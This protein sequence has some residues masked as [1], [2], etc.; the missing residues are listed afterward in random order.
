MSDVP[1]CA[2]TELGFRSVAGTL[3]GE[4][5]VWAEC[6]HLAKQRRSANGKRMALGVDGNR[7]ENPARTG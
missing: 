3:A 2:I 6:G 1:H 7:Q 5:R 4:I